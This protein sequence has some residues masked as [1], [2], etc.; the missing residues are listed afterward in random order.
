MAQPS[1]NIQI[2]MTWLARW[3]LLIASIVATYLPPLRIPRCL[4]MAVY[5]RGWQRRVGN[6]WESIRI[7]SNGRIL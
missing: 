3:T 1:I 4:V 2:R 5:N 7:D 6:R